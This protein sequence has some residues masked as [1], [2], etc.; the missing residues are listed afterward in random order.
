MV[1]SVKWMET[2]RSFEI[3]FSLTMG[4]TADMR[5][6]IVK[7]LAANLKRKEPSLDDCIIT[8]LVRTRVFIRLKWLNKAKSGASAQRRSNKQVLQHHRSCL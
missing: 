7:R 8:K 4:Q 6:G 5:P 3:I 1:P 2:V